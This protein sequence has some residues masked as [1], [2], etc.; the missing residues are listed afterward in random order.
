MPSLLPESW[1]KYLRGRESWSEIVINL[2]QKPII[3][4][5]GALK[6]EPRKQPKSQNE[7]FCFFSVLLDK[8]RVI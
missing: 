5:S 8:C 6:S 7:N 4:I 2:I 3:F 1:W